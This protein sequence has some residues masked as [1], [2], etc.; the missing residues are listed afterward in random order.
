[1]QGFDTIPEA[2]LKSAP[3]RCRPDLQTVSLE[4]DG[5]PAW[6]IKDPFNLAYFELSDEAFFVL[7]QLDGRRTFHEICQSFHTA[8]R[9]RTLSA[10]T[11]RGFVGQLISQNLVVAEAPGYGRTLVARQDSMQSRQRWRMLSNIMAIRFRGFDPDR[12]LAG[13]LVWLGWLFTPFALLTGLL[14]IIAAVVL[15]TVQFDQLLARLPDAQALM[16]VP[17]LVSL[18]LL[19]AAVKVLHEFGHGLTCKRFGGE[20]HE[21]GLMLLVFTPTL[22]CNVSDVWMVKDK[23]KR[24]AV[25]VAGMW[26]EAVI[27]ATCTLLWWLSAPG[28]FHSLCLN[29]I[30]LCGVSTFIFNGNPL[31]RYDGYFV[32]SD[33]LEIPNLQQQAAATIRARLCQTFC[34]FDPGEGTD[35]SSRR[36]SSLLAY[37]LASAGYRLM[38]AFLILWGIYHWL[39]PYGL[40]APVQLFALFTLGSMALMPVVGTITFLRKPANRTRV[41]WPRFWLLVVVTLTSVIALGSIPLPCHVP[42]RALADDDDVG[43]VYVTFAGTLAEAV[44]I[45]QIVDEGQ[46]IAQLEDPRLKV[47]LTRLEGELNQQRSLLEQ[48]ERRRVAEQN[49][50]QTIPTVRESVRD[51]EQQLLQRQRDAERLV[52][53]SPRRGTVLSAS[54]QRGSATPNALRGWTGYPL[55]AVNRGSYL[56]AGTPLCFIGDEYSRSAVLTISQDDINLVRVGQRV[57]VLWKELSG[58]IQQ[59]RIVE[60]A[61]FDAGRLTHEV[62]VRLNVPARVSADG[63]LRPVGNWYQARVKLDET[64]APLLHNATGSAKIHVQPR[65]LYQR[66][67]RWLKRTFPL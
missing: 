54:P 49:V 7:N 67:V 5:R 1:M 38:L 56:R 28:L 53:R 15:V 32:L 36:Q 34:G 30:F 35:L 17:N 14:L 12:M 65:T 59:G 21:M 39:S 62:A 33:W 29:L 6:G 43:R 19:L 20:C 23:W 44:R 3:W 52:I 60:L 11:L 8:F 64:T 61:G 57:Q 18:S 42:A 4:F 25:S 45:G 13:A 58:E 22:Y 2:D 63:S 51:L 66:A 37:G 48:L 16:S 27:A 55:D 31:L 24:I 50:A 46:V 10:Q 41:H 47:L 40:G 9:P 26:V